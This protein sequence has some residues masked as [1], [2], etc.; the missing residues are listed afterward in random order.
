MQKPQSRAHPQSRC[1][2]GIGTAVA[3]PRRC[4]G[5]GRRRIRHDDDGAD[6]GAATAACIAEATSAT[7]AVSAITTAPAA[8]A[9]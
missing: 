4:N 5:G 2:A 7:L 3:V 6:A 9:R 1:S 8:P